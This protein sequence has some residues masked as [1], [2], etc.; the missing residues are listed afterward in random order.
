MP[1]R[2]GQMRVV[3]ES[4]LNLLRESVRVGRIPLTIKRE[5]PLPVVYH[6]QLTTAERKPCALV[7]E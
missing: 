6:V 1:L 2:H 3:V 4:P 7:D 5:N